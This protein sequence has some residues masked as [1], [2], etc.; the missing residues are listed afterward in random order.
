MTYTST[1]SARV[2]KDTITRIKA[3]TDMLALCDRL[4][5]ELKRQGNASTGSASRYMARCPFHEDKTPS[6][7]VNAGKGLFHCFGCGEKGD[8]FALVEKV[9]G[10]GFQEAV[11]YLADLSG[12]TAV[13]ETGIPRTLSAA[14]LEAPQREPEARPVEATFTDK[15]RQE[16]LSRVVAV[17]ETNLAAS[18]EAEEYLR[19]TRGITDNQ[20]IR[21][22]RT[23]YANGN[24]E[25]RVAADSRQYHLLQE[26]GILNGQGR[27]VFTGCLV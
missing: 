10:I 5:I 21:Y 27:E 23:G 20:V 12:V 24:L 8:V 13:P 4:G 3:G 14:A 16:A 18:P 15:E 7:S 17:Y 19:K 1:G 2:T 22:F 11:R 26:L 6:L 25:K 9:K